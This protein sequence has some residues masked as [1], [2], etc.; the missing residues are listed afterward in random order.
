MIKRLEDPKNAKYSEELRTFAVTLKFYSSK[1]YSYARRVF[2]KCLPAPS[3]VRKWMQVVD[4]SPGF[5]TQSL[6][7]IKLRAKQD[8][9][10]PVDLVM[11]E[12]SIRQQT[13]SKCGKTYGKIDLGAKQLSD[14]NAPEA[15]NALVLMAVSL[16][17]GWKVPF[18]YFLIK[19]L[20]AS[21]RANILS[22]ALQQLHEAQADVFS[23][24][25][26]GAYHNF[27]ALICLG[28]N[29]DYPSC[30]FRPYI[31]HPTTKNQVF[32]FSDPCHNIKLVRNALGQ[33][34]YLLT[35]SEDDT[36]R[37][38]S[39]NYICSLVC[40]EEK[41][42]RKC[43]TKITKKHIFFEDNIMN[44]GL[45]AQTLSESVA[46]ALEFTRS[47]Q[48]PQFEGS[49]E[50]ETFCR[51]FN[52]AFDILNCR[53]K[54]S[55]KEYCQP[56]DVHSYS[57]LKNEADRIIQYIEGLS[58]AM[59][60][61][62]T[63]AGITTVSYKEEPALSCRK[64]TGFLGFV[65]SLKNIFE[66]FNAL[67]KQSSLKMT[68][69]LTY[70]LSQDHLE[71]FF[72]AVRSLGGHN[73]NPNAYQFETAYKHLIIHNEV[74]CSENANVKAS[75]INVLQISSS[76]APKTSVK[77][78]VDIEE[79][80][81]EIEDGILNDEEETATASTSAT[82]AATK[83]EGE[84]ILSSY[85]Q[86]VVVYISGFVARA[87]RKKVLSCETCR[88]SLVSTTTLLSENMQLLRLKNRGGLT[89][90]SE[91]VI[92]LCTEAEKYLRKN[93]T[94]TY[95]PEHFVNMVKHILT[96]VRCLVFGDVRDHVAGEDE[97]IIRE[98]HSDHNNTL[99]KL[100]LEQYY[101]IIRHHMLKSK[102]IKN[103]Y[104]RR[105]LTKYIL[106]ANE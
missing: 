97:E 17:H 70:K 83:A 94:N 9:R 90:P 34:P 4:G 65:V 14:D 82:S 80:I 53:S 30:N 77:I 35:H 39:W 29:F 15:T 5:T 102:S 2:K 57:L 41:E 18:A 7:L 45:A 40:L 27:A 42:E 54:Y 71:S 89:V 100:I 92:I 81:D 21:E 52:K 31:S 61:K 36:I 75:D 24:T 25:F 63:E 69:L 48:L 8:G 84:C 72:S 51:N 49:E 67:T 78:D 12:M 91:N 76:K 50:T 106:F 10:I 19:G 95:P 47:L 88:R 56:L 105:R 44:V 104:C 96:K 60:K 93:S 62:S 33:Q 22:E 79:L 26:D 85:I 37:K 87:V 74:K 101:N 13:L 38:I 20:N 98:D 23:I 68:Y 99:I 6:E 16:K 1:A 46:K 32:A 59:E 3:T 86:E 58:I 55:T 73:N 66:I 11:D 103:S 64:K 28:A 43:A